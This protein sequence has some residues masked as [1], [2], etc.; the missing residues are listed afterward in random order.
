M[1]AWDASLPTYY[2]PYVLL[3]HL[4]PNTLQYERIVFAMLVWHIQKQPKMGC[5]IHMVG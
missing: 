5:L 2:T 4:S 1:S 3:R